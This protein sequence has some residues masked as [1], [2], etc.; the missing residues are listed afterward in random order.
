MYT[1][2][3]PKFLFSHPF[4]HARFEPETSAGEN[5]T[6]G[7][8]WLGSWCTDVSR[9]HFNSFDTFQRVSVQER[10][11]LP[12]IAESVYE[13]SILIRAHRVFG[14]RLLSKIS[15]KLA[16]RKLGLPTNMKPEY[17]YD[18][19]IPNLFQP[20]CYLE[21]L[22]SP[23]ERK[24]KNKYVIG[25]HARMAGSVSEW[26]EVISYLSE[27]GLRMMIRKIN[28]V[29]EKHPDYTIFIA[30]DTLKVISMFKSMF[31]NVVSTSG[32]KLEHGGRSPSRSGI[33]LSALELF[34]LSRCDMLLLTK[35]SQFSS[36]AHHLST[37]NIPAFYFWSVCWNC[38]RKRNTF[39]SSDFRWERWVKVGSFDLYSLIGVDPY[40]EL[41]SRVDS[42]LTLS[43]ST[44]QRLMPANKKFYRFWW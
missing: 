39:E 37:R 35:Q 23:Y 6:F 22:L 40:Q 9:D 29:T 42:C 15:N 26:G 21:S 14:H 41:T 1:P 25:V 16:L 27:K 13:G 30:S 44:F 10:D 43:E 33:I 4:I 31:K 20:S 7:N 24:M 11:E 8:C 38:E 34:L 28:A 18:L 12:S 17:W 32:Y 36:V 19:C 2:S 5:D 3:A